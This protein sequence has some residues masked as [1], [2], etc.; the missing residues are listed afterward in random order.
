[1]KKVP[2]VEL[3]MQRPRAR[4][5]DEIGGEQNERDV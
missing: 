4:H 5:P 1:L 2:A 3:I